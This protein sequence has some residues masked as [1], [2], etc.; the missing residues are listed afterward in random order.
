MR[1]ALEL[2]VFCWLLL[3]L[4]LGYASEGRTGAT[5]VSTLEIVFS[6]AHNYIQSFSM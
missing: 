2:R 5:G 3:V 4:A 6:V 1:S